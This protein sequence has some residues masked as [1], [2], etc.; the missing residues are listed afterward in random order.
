[1]IS[2][3]LILTFSRIVWINH[4]YIQK[5]RHSQFDYEGSHLVFHA[6][7]DD[8]M[9]ASYWIRDHTPPDSVVIYPLQSYK[10]TNTF[11]ERLSYVKQKLGWYVE[12]IPAYGER[13]LRL[14]V[15]YSVDTSRDDYRRILAEM[16]N[17]LPGRSLYAVVDNSVLSARSDGTAE[18]GSGIRARRLWHIRLPVESRRRRVTLVR[19]QKEAHYL[20]LAA[21]L[22]LEVFNPL[23][24]ISFALFVSVGYI[25]S[26][27]TP[28]T[29]DLWQALLIPC[30]LI[31][32][33]WLLSGAVKR[34]KQSQSDAFQFSWR[35]FLPLVV[36]AMVLAPGLYAIV[37]QPYS[38]NTFTSRSSF[39]VHQSVALRLHTT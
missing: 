10:Y 6:G 15:F 30:T 31:P 18:R 36:P 16:E 20:K 25:F 38:A 14:S 33:A 5:A 34:S 39:R 27:L 11:H 2:V 22:I 19:L 37:I 9:D 21:I 32:F 12:N 26:L 1:M 29:I 35:V 8:Q 13:V 3:F 28:M 7:D 24:A 4:F 23:F 17:E